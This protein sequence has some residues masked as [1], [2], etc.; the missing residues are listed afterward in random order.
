MVIRIHW[1]IPRHGHLKTPY[2]RLDTHKCRACWQC[3]EACPRHVLGKAVLLK[4]RHAHV[5]HAD[6]CKGCQ[7]CV[8]VC[9]NEAI[10]YTGPPDRAGNRR[11]VPGDRRTAASV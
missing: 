9:P 7:K 6:A 4:H 5:D 10:I 8:K 11:A 3:V 1:P 2:I